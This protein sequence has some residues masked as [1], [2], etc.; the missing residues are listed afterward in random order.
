V[1]AAASGAPDHHPALTI[2]NSSFALFHTMSAALDSGLVVVDHDNIICFLNTRAEEILGIASQRAYGQG[3]ITLIRDY[4]ADALAREVLQDGET[5]T[6]TIQLMSSGRTLR[7]RCTPIFSEDSI[8]GAVLLIRD[9]TQISLLERSRRDLVANVSHELRTPLAS[10]KLLVETLQSEPPPDV[11][12]RMMSQMMHE[13]EAVIQL[14][15]EL[16]ELA[17]IESGRVVMQFAPGNMAQMIAHIL[18]RIRPQAGR[19]QIQVLADAADSAHPVLVD[20]HRIG[21]VLLNLLH[22]AVKFTAEG[23]SISVQTRV[24]MVDE[25]TPRVQQTEHHFDMSI[26]L[27]IGLVEREPSPQ[28]QPRQEVRHA[29]EVG[30]RFPPSHPPGLWMLISVSDTG[31]GIPSQDLPRIF[32]RFYKVDRSRTRNSG[33]TGLGLAIAK[34]LIEGHGGRLWA[35]S[36]EGQGSTFY[37]TL[38]I[39]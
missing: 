22:N 32:E 36:E 2:E 9:M 27:E 25:K 26:P 10:L 19:K 35:T 23:G 17:H 37:F 34:H 6:T 31:I 33:G 5:R 38:P 39:A 11:A 15:E 20:E 8:V 18:E 1:E 12:Q 30:V 4:Q 3:L 16:H 21:Q 7:L 28:T 13:I 24:V 14:A 29:E